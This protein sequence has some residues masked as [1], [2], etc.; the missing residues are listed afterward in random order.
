MLRLLA[1]CALLLPLAVLGAPAIDEPMMLVAQPDVQ[2][3]LFESSI[4]F[5]KP[6]TS[7]SSST[8]GPLRR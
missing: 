6:A 4:L 7:A 5:V 8:A 1:F 2:G 3:A